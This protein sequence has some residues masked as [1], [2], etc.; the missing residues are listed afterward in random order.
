MKMT[1]LI[2]LQLGRLMSKMTDAYE[3]DHKK[4]ECGD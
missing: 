2:P 3:Q 4:I 1:Y